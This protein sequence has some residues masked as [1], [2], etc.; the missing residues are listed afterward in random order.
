[1]PDNQK[2]FLPLTP[3]QVR[4]LESNGCSAVDW[5]TVLVHKGLI[6]PERFHSVHFS[7]VV[8]LEEQ[9]GAVE[10]SDT[11]T[12]AC[13]ITGAVLHNVYVAG[14]VYIRNVKNRIENFTICSGALV[15]NVDL[16]VTDGP[17]GFGNGVRVSVVCEAG[18]REVMLYDRL[19]AQIAH[20]LAMGRHRPLLIEKLNEMIRKYVRTVTSEKGTIGAGARVINCG[21]LRNCRIGGGAVV[22]SAA[23]LE[24]VSINSSLEDPARV[25]TGCILRDSIVSAGAKVTDAVQLERCFVGQ[26]VNVSKAF[27]GQDSL[28]FANTDVQQ[29]EGCSIFAGPFCVSH[30]KSSLLLAGQ[31][32]F[33]NAGSGTNQSNHMYKLGPV[34]QGVLERG[35]KTGSGAYIMWPARIGA[36]SLVL[37][38]IYGNPDTSDLPFSYVVEQ[39]GQ[40]RCIPGICLRNV[41]LCR[42]EA[43]WPTRDK[44]KGTD[45]LDQVIFDLLSPYTA[46]KIMNAIEILEQLQARGEVQDGIFSF[47]SVKIAGRNLETGILLYRM[48]LDGYLGGV[49]IERLRPGNWDASR[50]PAEILKTKTEIGKKPWLDL[51]GL[52][53]PGEGLDKLMEFIENEPVDSVRVLEEQFGR[54][55]KNYREYEWTWVSGA[56]DRLTGKAPDRLDA[57]EIAA[58]LNRYLEAVGSLYDMRCEDAMRE[59]QGPPYTGFGMDTNAETARKDFTAVRGSAEENEFLVRMG[60]KVKSQLDNARAL[61]AKLTGST[62]L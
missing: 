3:S 34:H 17:T 19:T 12:A 44:R 29:G 25:G 14:D 1:M 24:N 43:K 49:L 37:G 58:L 28:F 48:A 20:L 11:L 31:M 36:F 41:G 52:F 15:D 6:D 55:Y 51:C 30:H 5:Q 53:V 18:G 27:T 32:S 47:G 54:V 9:K 50:N 38:R 62:G 59:F 46:G 26:A 42:D 45:R 57:A 22:D 2:Q 23:R 8:H 10:L 61:I 4:Q 56:I 40:T 33:F 7:G 60:E 21:T 16:L 35:V 39:D 13:G